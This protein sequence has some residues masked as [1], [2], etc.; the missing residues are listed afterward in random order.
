VVGGF[1]GVLNGGGKK[2]V[3]HF[4]SNGT[5]VFEKTRGFGHGLRPLIRG[6]APR[7]R[8]RY[9]KKGRN[10]SETGGNFSKIPRSG[11]RSAEMGG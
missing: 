8:T 2:E 4:Q 6:S 11:G 10:T 9:G 1:G 5:T 7:G 3:F